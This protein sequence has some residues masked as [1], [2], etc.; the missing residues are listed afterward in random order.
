M[1]STLARAAAFSLVLAATGI[2]AET[3]DKPDVHVGDLWT[4]Q[5][6]NGLANE[7]DYTAIEDVLEVSDTEIKA[8]ERVRGKP[9]SSVASFTRE[10]NPA[11]VSFARYDPYLRELSFPL[12]VGK[13]WDASADKMLFSNGKHGKFFLKGEVLAF[14]KVTVP[15]GT[16]DAYKVAL[17]IDATGTDED[18]NIGNT[19]ETIWYA[20]AVRRFV[21]YENT[22]SRDGRVRTKDISELTDYSLR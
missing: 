6:T 17:H 19:V 20:P 4:W 1:G 11:D 13:K 5:H 18:A 2:H 9:N 3:A 16:F 21:K 12:Q 22:Y 10:W 15:A 8:R 7:R 14:E